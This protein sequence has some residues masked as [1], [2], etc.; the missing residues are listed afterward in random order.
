MPAWQW[1]SPRSRPPP[2]RSPGCSPNGSIKGKP[3]VLGIISGAVAG[4]VAITPASG[5]VDPRG[6]LI[7]GIAA[8]VVCYWATTGLKHA[9]GYDDSLDAFG[10]H[11]VGGIVGAILTGVLAV[12]WVGGEGKSG[13]IDGNPHQVLVQLY[14][15]AVTVVYDVIVSLDPAQTGRSYDRAAGRRGSR[16]RRSRPRAPRRGRA[17]TQILRGQPAAAEIGP[18]LQ[19]SRRGEAMKKSRRSSSRSNSTKSRTRCTRSA[20]PG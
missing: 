19:S 1:R 3:S 16:T 18:G 15:V 14:G 6:A 8:G 7:I 13:L 20:S 5:F 9:L 2:R 17:V 12:A 4:L 11:G 10:V